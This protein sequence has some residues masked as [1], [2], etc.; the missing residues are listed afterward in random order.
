M[1]ICVFTKSKNVFPDLQE[2]I[3]IEFGDVQGVTQE[4]ISDVLD[5]SCPIVITGYS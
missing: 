2:E 3:L 5:D 4:K 1:D